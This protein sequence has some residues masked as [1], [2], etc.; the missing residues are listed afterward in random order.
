MGTF[1]E[2]YYPVCEREN[3]LLYVHEHYVTRV[4]FNATG[5]ETRD[6]VAELSSPMEVPL[7]VP[8]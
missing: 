8:H 5:V 6:E 1:T 3:L 2:Q 7:V 4:C